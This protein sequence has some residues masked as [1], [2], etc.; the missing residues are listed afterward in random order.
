MAPV[1]SSG[2]PIHAEVDIATNAV[3]YKRGR[4]DKVR[5]KLIADGDLIQ[6]RDF[7]AVPYSGEIAGA[8]NLRLARGDSPAMVETKLTL[9][10]IDSR[11]LDDISPKEPRG[12]KGAISGTIE[13]TAPVVTNVNPL[14]GATGSVV[15]SG[16][17]GS[18]GKAGYATK[19]LAALR[20][21][22]IL[23]LRLPSLKDEGL[24]YDKLDATIHMQNGFMTIDHFALSGPSLTAAAS[25]QID[26]PNDATGIVVDVYPLETLT[27][28]VDFVPVVGAATDP[29]RKQMGIRFHVTGSTADP[30]VAL[31]P[32]QNLDQLK[33]DVKSGKEVVDSIKDKAVEKIGN[34]IGGIFGGKQP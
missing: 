5:A 30:K 26:W 29:L 34:A 10:G 15:I 12:F 11:I 33:V 21:T 9:N 18:L 6:L 28:I 25:G 23:Q 24:V 20:T 7:S 2:K 27:G 22:E 4:F 14:T 1:A 16:V 19:V 13:M 3:Y 32:G 31:A 17:K 8:I